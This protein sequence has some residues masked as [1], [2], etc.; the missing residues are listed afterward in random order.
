MRIRSLYGTPSNNNITSP[1]SSEHPALVASESID[2]ARGIIP[3]P[4]H[5]DG[6]WCASAPTLSV[7][8]CWRGCVQLASSVVLTVVHCSSCS[9]LRGLVSP[10]GESLSLF[11]SLLL[12]LFLS[13][14]CYGRRVLC[15]QSNYEPATSPTPRERCFSLAC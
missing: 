3:D 14:A 10:W 5:A 7:C 13:L 15:Q 12:S 2:R 4:I 9:M 8:Y 11:L 1:I 6:D